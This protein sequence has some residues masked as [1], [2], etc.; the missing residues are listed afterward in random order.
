MQMT[1]DVILSDAF[2]VK[3]V[4][5]RPK[6]ARTFQDGGRERTSNRVSCATFKSRSSEWFRHLGKH[7]SQENLGIIHV[8][9]TA[10]PNLS[11]IHTRAI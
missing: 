8:K 9:Q 3:S 4:V 2:L 7:S 1:V 11:C 5:P 10:R 6:I